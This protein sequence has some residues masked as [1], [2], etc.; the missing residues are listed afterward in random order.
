MFDGRQ[1]RTVRSLL[2]RC[3]VTPAKS[4]ILAGRATV[5][6][7]HLCARESTDELVASRLLIVNNRGNIA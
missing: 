1:L 3:T 7:L 4:S 2:G 5:S 6:S